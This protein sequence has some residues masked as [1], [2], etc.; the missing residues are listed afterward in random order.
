MCSCIYFADSLNFKVVYDRKPKIDGVINRQCNE[1]TMDLIIFF[2]KL[3]LV[4]IRV[5]TV[6]GRHRSA[7][8]V[9][10]LY[11]YSMHIL[12]GAILI[13]HLLHSRRK[14]DKTQWPVYIA[15]GHT[16]RYSKN[17]IINR[18]RSINFPFFN[19]LPHCCNVL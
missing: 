13:N 3:E 18:S 9:H 17:A 1:L 12:H 15:N 10:Y 14:W 16:I 8:Q 4:V 5:Y 7:T 11:V 19:D 2:C 6:Y